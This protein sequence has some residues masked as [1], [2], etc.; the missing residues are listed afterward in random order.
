MPESENFKMFLSSAETWDLLGQRKPKYW[1]RT[2]GDG[3]LV[4]LC[5]KAGMNLA[6]KKKHLSL[7]N[8]TLQEVNRD[9]Y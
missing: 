8:T 1:K 7:G 2:S 9:S 5:R 3:S 6:Q 4:G